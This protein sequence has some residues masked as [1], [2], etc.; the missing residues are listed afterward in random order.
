MAL[1]VYFSTMKLQIVKLNYRQPIAC[2]PRWKSVYCYYCHELIK[3]GGGF[4]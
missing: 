2:C 1:V 4:M 3:V